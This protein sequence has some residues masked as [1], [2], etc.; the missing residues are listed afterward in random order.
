MIMALE[1]ICQQIL[2]ITAFVVALSFT[3]GPR[4]AAPNLVH[5][6]LRPAA[7]H[8]TDP[9][10]LVFIRSDKR[11]GVKGLES[12]PSTEP[13]SSPQEALNIGLE[14]RLTT[15]PLPN[16]P[17]IIQENHLRSPPLSMYSPEFHL[18]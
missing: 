6:P 11:S 1:A 3:G 9:A 2:R 17:L 16:F 8:K 18:C 14:V 7:I 12:N 4:I 15:K 13:I 5:D 10:Y